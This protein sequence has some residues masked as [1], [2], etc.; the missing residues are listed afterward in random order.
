MYFK[1]FDNW[2]IEKK[3]INNFDIKYHFNP[4]EIRW[5]SIG[6][7]IGS[8]IDGKGKQSNRP[9]LIINNAGNDLVLIAPLSTK[10]KEGK[11]Y[12]ILNVG[13]EKYS[14]CINQ[15]RVI[16]KKRIY[17]RIAKIPKNKLLEIFDKI[18]E[19]FR[20]I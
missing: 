13:T 8:E 1:D 7:N 3:N 17:S 16:S 6:V 20:P 14:V 19:Y 2:I 12:F 10:I 4:G 9:V 11:S 15:V 18:V 5:V